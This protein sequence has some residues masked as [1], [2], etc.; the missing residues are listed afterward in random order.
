MIRELPPSGNDGRSDHGQRNEDPGF[1]D[2]Q[3]RGL[4]RTCWIECGLNDAVPSRVQR[5]RRQTLPVSSRSRA[6]TKLN[7]VATTIHSRAESCG[8]GPAK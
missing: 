3:R 4:A 1:T 5:N 7:D 2:P 6:N 8:G